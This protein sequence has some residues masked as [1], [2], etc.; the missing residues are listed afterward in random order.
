MQT[1]E[2][3]GPRFDGVAEGITHAAGSPPALEGAREAGSGEPAEIPEAETESATTQDATP[4]DP[5]DL[6]IV[7]DHA[8]MQFNGLTALDDVSL[9]V[10]RGTIVGVVGPSGA[11]KTTLIR[12]LT[13]TLGATGG[14]VEVLG[15]N[16]RRFSRRTR[17]RLGYM[18]QLFTLYQDLSAAEN[19][20]F[21]ASLYGLVWFQRWRRVRE[22]LRFVG[23]WD[24]RRRRASELSGGMQRRLELACALVHE[25]A[26]LFLDE[27]TA[28]VD[29]ILRERIWG[30]LHRL[31]DAGRTL[32]VT[33]QYLG[34]AEECD[35]VALIAEGRLIAHA[36]PDQMRKDAMGGEL[37]DV[38]AGDGVDLA[39]LQGL[40][41]VRGIR[42]LNGDGVLRITVDDAGTATPLVVDAIGRAGGQVR[43]TSEA[44]PS[45]DEV[46]AELVDRDRR[47]RA[48]A[49]DA[50]AAADREAA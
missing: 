44:R 30:E 48:R 31:R 35:A 16:P 17:Q 10:A 39:V 21:V 29:P 18:P 26:V 38:D 43:S 28:G 4:V 47:E 32:L 42:R 37:I 15:Q 27:P 33:T 24:A 1:H 3:L 8:T 46:F 5:A 45:F 7:V 41:A 40:P 2:A 50:A 49:A 36:T 13:G 20:D 6:A 14:S 19:V 11:G 9:A 25:P 34:E 12:L 23:L 22:V